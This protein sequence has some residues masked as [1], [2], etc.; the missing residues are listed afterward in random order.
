MSNAIA[1]VAGFFLLIASL[2]LLFGAVI[3]LL[4]GTHPLLIP[5]MTLAGVVLAVTT[6]IGL[7]DA[8]VF[9]HAVTWIGGFGGY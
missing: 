9:K 7:F 6:I 4:G 2:T 1:I 8:R 5:G 3:F